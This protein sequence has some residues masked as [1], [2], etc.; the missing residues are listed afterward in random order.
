MGDTSDG[1]TPFY[2]VPH[3]LIHLLPDFLPCSGR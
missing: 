3:L 1:E 2:K